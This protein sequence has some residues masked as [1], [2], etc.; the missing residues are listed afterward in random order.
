YV[1]PAFVT[2]A[3]VGPKV[4]AA[5]AGLVTWV[6]NPETGAPTA[7]LVG[8]RAYSVV[9]DHLGTPVLMLDE[10]GRRVW[11]AEVSTWGEV[12][13]LVGEGG[14]CPHRFAGQYEDVE[15][16]LAYNRY[17]YFDPRAGQYLCVDPIRL[18]GGLNSF[19]YVGD[20]LTERDPLG[21][22]STGGDGC[23][24][25]D[26]LGEAVPPIEKTLDM[27]LEPQ[28]YIDAAVKKY[29]INLRG[30]GQQIHA[31]Y[32]PDLVSAGKSRAATPNVIEIGPAAL[33]DESELANTIAHE[34][35]HARSWLRGGDAPEATAYPAG[36]A[37]SDYIAGLK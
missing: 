37:L 26:R 34:L 13:V 19:A 25:R 35:N 36:N 1:E 12:R 31:I 14:D 17:R 16:G 27:A 10:A 28:L 11:A 32:N 18:A 24:V 29:G 9:C 33:R 15:T 8:G 3:R 7:K 6:S 4:V 22:A 30:S 21:L 20:P 2:R 5:P 23:G